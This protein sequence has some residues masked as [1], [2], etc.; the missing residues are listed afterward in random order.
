VAIDLP[1]VG[2]EVLGVLLGPVRGVV[3]PRLLG[4]A[5]EAHL[6][7][8][9]QSL[10]WRDVVGTN[11]LSAATVCRPSAVLARLRELAKRSRTN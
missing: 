9:G 11:S 6:L 5:P 10:Q 3:R 8:I 1:R 4:V 7:V 2:R